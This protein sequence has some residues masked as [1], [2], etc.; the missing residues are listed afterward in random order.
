MWLKI[1]AKMLYFYVGIKEM[2]SIIAGR[3]TNFESNLITF[4]TIRL[5]D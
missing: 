2:I 4:L 1:Y 3:L 5:Y